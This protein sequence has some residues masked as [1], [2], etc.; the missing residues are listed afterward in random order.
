MK[1]IFGHIQNSYLVLN[2]TEQS[3]EIGVDIFNQI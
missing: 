3:I 2:K 1:I